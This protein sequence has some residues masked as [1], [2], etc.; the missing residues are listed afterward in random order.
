MFEVSPHLRARYCTNN[1]DELVK[2]ISVS[3]CC[4]CPSKYQ[5]LSAS[6][7][8]LHYIQGYDMEDAMI[9]NKA[10]VERGFAHASVYKCEVNLCQYKFIHPFFYPVY[11]SWLFW[12]CS[13]LI[14][15]RSAVN[16]AT[17]LFSLVGLKSSY[18]E[19]RMR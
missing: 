1:T 9:L 2:R 3:V 13:S 8:H 16:M 15:P 19:P 10:T 6:C 7:T 14:W 12:Y 4:M 5:W 17:Q 18:F 11:P